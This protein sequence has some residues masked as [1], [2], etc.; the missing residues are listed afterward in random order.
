[1]KTTVHRLF[2][3]CDSVLQQRRKL[4]YQRRKVIVRRKIEN[5]I[6]TISW[7]IFFWRSVYLVKGK[8]SLITHKITSIEEKHHF[9]TQLYMIQ[10]IPVQT[11]KNA[12]DST[13][14]LIVSRLASWFCF[15]LMTNC[16]IIFDNFQYQRTN[17][18]LLVTFSWVSQQWIKFVPKKVKIIFFHIPRS[19]SPDR[20]LNYPNVKDSCIKKRSS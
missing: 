18:M 7:R 15:F 20:I 4:A 11:E 2:S 17:V 19:S 12:I 1:M 13:V 16:I 9:F 5:S 14:I 3:S 8:G 6:Q 10:S